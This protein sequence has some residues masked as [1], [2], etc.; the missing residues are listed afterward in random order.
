MLKRKFV[1]HPK[2][3]LVK[4]AAGFRKHAATG[5]HPKIMPKCGLR[6]Q[7]FILLSLKFDAFGTIIDIFC[8]CYSSHEIR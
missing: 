4:T 1:K 8:C 2:C 5:S 3:P 7:I 6:E